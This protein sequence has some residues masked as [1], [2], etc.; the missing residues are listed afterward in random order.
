MMSHSSFS[1]TVKLYPN[2]AQLELLR[3]SCGCRRYVY[4]KMLE[5]QKQ[6]YQDKLDGKVE[7]GYVRYEEMCS[8]LLVLKSAPDTAWLQEVNAQSLQQTIMDLD[9][10]FKRFFNG[11]SGYPTEK[12]RGRGDSFRLPQKC[13]VSSDFGAVLLPKIGWVPCRGLRKDKLTESTGKSTFLSVQSVT[14]KAVADHFEA[15]VLFRVLSPEPAQHQRPESSC[16][17]DVGIAKPLAVADDDNECFTYGTRVR[18]R[19]RRHDLYVKRLQRRLARQQKSSRSRAR[20]KTKLQRAYNHASNVCKDFNHQLSNHLART[21]QFVV[22]EALPLRNMTASAAGTVEEPGKNV[23][24][25]S[26]LNREMLRLAPGQFNTYL[27]YKCRREGGELIRVNPAYSSCEC[28]ECHFVSKEN[29]KNQAVFKCM[30]P[31]CRHT[32]NADY[33]AAKVLRYRGLELLKQRRELAQVEGAKCPVKPKPGC[34]KTKR[35]FTFAP[36]STTPR[37]DAPPS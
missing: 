11:F 20:T 3:R 6:R 2:Q 19:L 5:L 30:N 22:T 37:P 8:L 9:K 17:V 10:A 35:Q 24:Q 34:R 33:N 23:A 15:V 12:K 27:E 1:N 7:Y 21:Y 25:K 36:C 18:N 31:G 32:E 29:R 26:G 4:N 28:S 16:G 13:A 14:V